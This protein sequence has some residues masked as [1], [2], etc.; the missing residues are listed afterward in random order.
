MLGQLL[1]EPI[2]SWRAIAAGMSPGLGRVEKQAAAGR[3]VVNALREA[4]GLGVFGEHAEKCRAI[5]VVADAEPDGKRKAVQTA[6]QPFVVRSVAP[7]LLR[8]Q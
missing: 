4:I 3:R 7:I 1:L 2:L 8:S 5:I 6:P